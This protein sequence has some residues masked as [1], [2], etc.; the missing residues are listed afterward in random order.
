VG[1][2]MEDN[3]ELIVEEI[4]QFLTIMLAKHNLDPLILSSVILARLMLANEY[5]G[6]DQDFKKLASNLTTITKSRKEIH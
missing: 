6:S 1:L 3:M 5:V 2:N 4:D